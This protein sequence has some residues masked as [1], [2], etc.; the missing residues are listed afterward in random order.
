[1][2]KII[3]IWL[4]VAGFATGEGLVDKPHPRLWF[5]KSA[6]AGLRERLAKDPLAAKLHTAVLKEA[7]RVLDA[8]VCR[9]EIPD[10]KRLLTQSRLA[11][12]QIMHS[13]WAWRLTGEEKFR[14]R[15]IAEL[16][17]ASS[18]KDWNPSHF[19]DTAEM[20]T[21][22]ATGY[23]WLYH[24]L[25]PSQRATY[26]RALVEKALKPAKTVYDKGGWWTIPKNN[27]AQVCGGG[28]GIAAVAV[29]ELEPEL[30]GYLYQKGRKLVRD[31][32][33]F[34]APDGMYPE[35][36]GYWHFGTNYHVM[37]LAAC[38]ALG[39][40]VDEDPV[41][42]KAGDAI[43]H[44]TS[45]TRLSFN[46]ADG[47]ASREVPSPAQGWLAAHYRNAVQARHIRGLLSRAMDE[48]GR[49]RTDRYFPL[50]VLWLPGVPPETSL[51]NAAVFRGEQAMAMFR[52]G[53]DP[54]DAYLAIK[55]GTP[56][57]SHGH[58]DVGSF[59]YDA[60]GERWIHDLG[61][62]DY[63]LPGYFG[64]KRW[65]YYRLQNRSHNTLEIGGRLQNPNSKPCPLIASSLTDEVAGASFD[66]S[67]AYADSAGKVVRRVRFDKRSGTTGIEDLVSAP[68]GAILWRAFT[69]AKA[70]IDGYDLVLRK[71]GRQIT[72]RD[73]S[74]IGTWRI[75]SA[76]PPT[77]EEH[78]NTDITVLVL[79]VPKSP[80]VKIE[81]EIRP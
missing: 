35:G 19:L 12:H 18:L 9:H 23:D 28:I 68:S 25:T 78:Q 64:S 46:F 20:A 2:R 30:A 7:E 60:H 50:S 77:P 49:F 38:E 72:L 42:E 47:G 80:N 58:M 53:W 29:A 48:G 74:Q 39:Q 67:D 62:E 13:A 54:G 5:P 3:W 43:M 1:V 32:G 22:V 37:F 66:L 73:V 11:L 75:E 71:K 65:N 69:D 31:C 41:M 15:T 57:A 44:L 21:A 27:W 4:V 8:P 81:V 45:P 40:P 33:V 16:D 24:T 26:E 61:K 79:E 55:G 56:A 76:K 51:P 10:G 63:N 52:T 70:E 14:L 17:A 36:P 59:V 6:E 34:Y